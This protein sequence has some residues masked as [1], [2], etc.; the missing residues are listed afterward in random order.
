M[1]LARLDRMPISLMEIVAV[2]DEAGEIEDLEFVYANKVSQRHLSPDGPPLAGRRLSDV[3]SAGREA[4]LYVHSLEA[5]R[6]GR[7]QEY[8]TRNAVH[9]TLKNMVLRAVITPKGDAATICYHPFSIET[10][11]QNEHDDQLALFQAVCER[12]PLGVTLTLDD[13]ELLFAN[14]AV[15][16]LLGYAPGELKGVNIVQIVA[17]AYHKALARMGPDLLSGERTETVAEWELVR[18]TGEHIRVL[19]VS[20]CLFSK[21][22]GRHVFIGHSRDVREDYRQ[23]EALKAALERAEQATRLKSEFLANMSHEIRTPLNGVIGM[24]QALAH[25]PLNEDQK[26]QVSTIVESGQTLMSLLNDILDLSKIEAGRMEISPVAGDLRHKLGRL[27]KLYEVRAAEKGLNL[28]L[29]VHPSVPSRLVFDPVRVR[30]CVGNLVSNAIKFSEKG[31]ILVV[32][33]SQPSGTG[34]HFIT[35]HVADQGIGIA[36]EK[37]ARI[38]DAFAQADGSTTRAYGGTGLGLSITRRLA[39]LMGGDV[40]VTS[41]PGRGSVFILTFEAGTVV[42]P[43]QTAAKEIGSTTDQG[44]ANEIRVRNILV[45]DDNAINRRVARSLLRHHDMNVIEAENGF[46][47]IARL[48]ETPVDIVLMDIHMPVLDGTEALRRIRSSGKPYANVP[49]IALTADSMRGDQQRFLS[50]GFDGYLAKPIDER[51]MMQEIGRC[52][53]GPEPQRASA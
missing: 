33:S 8:T 16:D 29:V 28:R 51:M 3:L 31:D 47:A 17:P 11:E 1:D 53:A 14:Q 48:E 19:S 39:R 30:Q 25:T 23:R 21:F 18:K 9:E 15:H 37:Q 2:R 13:G 27:Q 36:P 6:S 46:D 26:D 35:V 49:V 24:A 38:F 4:R 40:T 32:V 50:A 7:I 45:V 41:E 44:K 5:I 10:D 12:G 42:L 43:A 52:L 20:N 34:G 22:R